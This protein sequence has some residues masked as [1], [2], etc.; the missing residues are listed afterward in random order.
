MP[1][2]APLPYPDSERLVWLEEASQ[3]NAAVRPGEALLDWQENSQ[4]WQHCPGRRRPENVDRRGGT[5]KGR[6]RHNFGELLAG[7]RRAD[8]G[9]R[10]KLTS[11][12]DRPGAERVAILSNGL[13]QS[14]YNRDQDIVG[15]TITINDS[16]FT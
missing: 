9:G 15:K 16:A 1:D 11:A 8:T 2:I 6:R 14:R 12:E 7:A 10:A 4:T 13:W 3:S 5:R